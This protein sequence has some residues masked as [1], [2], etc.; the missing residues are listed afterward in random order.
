MRSVNTIRIA[1]LVEF[2][3]LIPR[4][5]AFSFLGFS[6]QRGRQANSVGLEN[7]AGKASR[8]FPPEGHSLITHVSTKG[9]FSLFP[10]AMFA[11]IV[12]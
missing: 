2:P 4:R 9:R 7:V 11:A 8:Y 5:A 10:A 6:I 3:H 12:R 1:A